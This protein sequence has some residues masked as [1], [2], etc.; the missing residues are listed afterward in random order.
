MEKEERTKLLLDWMYN[1]ANKEQQQE[2]YKK[3]NKQ[4]P[5]LYAI[6]SIYDMCHDIKIMDII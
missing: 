1:H 5:A 2:V 3:F 6:A 4:V